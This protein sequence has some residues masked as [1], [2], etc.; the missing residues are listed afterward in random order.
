MYIM[1]SHW[2][3]CGCCNDV[4]YSKVSLLMKA[5][6][7]EGRQ[8]QKSL[9]SV[10]KCCCSKDFISVPALFEFI[11]C[12]GKNG[13][14]DNADGISF[15][16]WSTVFESLMVDVIGQ[17]AETCS[18]GSEPDVNTG[19]DNVGSGVEINGSQSMSSS[20]PA[21]KW[22]SEADEVLSYDGKFIRCGG[23]SGCS[24]AGRRWTA[25]IANDGGG[26][27]VSKSNEMVVDSESTRGFK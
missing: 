17:Y 21:S 9:P 22:K 26:W 2:G 6:S 5:D 12:A 14:R 23:G 25:D 16:F 4:K 1:N 3:C 15:E 7:N 11:D 10:G 24:G 19:S 18:D 13:R 27:M 8:K 20:G